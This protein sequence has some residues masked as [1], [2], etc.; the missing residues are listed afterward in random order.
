MI[1]HSSQILPIRLHDKQNRK[2]HKMESLRLTGQEIEEISRVANSIFTSCVN[3]GMPFQQVLIS[4]YLSGLEHGTHN[5][6]LEPT[7]K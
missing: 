7:Q 1:K 4:V 3:V 5:Q 2:P 6:S